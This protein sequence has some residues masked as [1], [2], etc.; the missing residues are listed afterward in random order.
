MVLVII[1]V[2]TK[3]IVALGMR[4]HSLSFELFWFISV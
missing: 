3:T 4:M 1:L 2:L